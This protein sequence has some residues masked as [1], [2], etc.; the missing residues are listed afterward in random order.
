MR[1]IDTIEHSIG[2]LRKKKLRTFLTTFGVVIGI[3]ALVSMVSFGLGIE[4]NVTEQFKRMEL[5]NY[6]MAFS[7]NSPF[8]GF[9]PGSSRPKKKVVL[10]EE[11]LEEIRSL[12]GVESAFPDARFPAQIRFGD[13]EEFGFVQILPADRATQDLIQLRAGRFF[14]SKDAQSVIVS[15]T[16]LRGAGVRDFE[17][18]VGK[19]IELSSLYF[20][21]GRLKDLNFSG[22][23]PIGREVY[24]LKIEGVSSRMGM[25]SALPIRS[26]VFLPEGTAG[27]MKKLVLTSLW[28][29]FSSAGGREYG[30]VNVRVASPSDLETVK[31]QL[32]ELGL[33][34][35]ALIDQMEEIKKSFLFLDMIL[36]AVGMIAIVVAA[37]GII[38]TMVMSILERYAEIGIMK[39]V[40][41]SDRDVK[42]IFFFES[43]TIGFMGGIFG[44]ALGW[45][46]SQVINLVVNSYLGGQGVPQFS[47]FSFPW[48]L[49]VGAVF[50]AVLVSLAAGLY[51]AARAS[52]VDPVVA[53]RHN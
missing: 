17:S 33:Q 20:D 46:V 37:L 41:A 25:G 47:Y 32:Q 8:G 21:L 36:A 4:R 48:W 49:I 39:A 11:I 15:D 22:G 19:T 51:P 12:K 9:L 45:V 29:L 43:G 14:T 5:F 13:R 26:D 10:N 52:G 2:S 50:F 44:F 3:G 16:F 28:D 18:V 34:T 35:F 23:L 6:V 7:G 38:N 24:S 42:K 31:A 27:R 53:L 30:L 1:I 40:G